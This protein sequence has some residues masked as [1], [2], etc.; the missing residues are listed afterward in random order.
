MTHLFVLTS[1]VGAHLWIFVKIYDYP[2]NNR[3]NPEI[4]AML[5]RQAAK[6]IIDVH[7]VAKI[8]LIKAFLF[9]SYSDASAEYP[10]D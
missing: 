6:L 7:F 10:Q 9:L 2:L 4:R 5:S 8:A 1:D 3:A